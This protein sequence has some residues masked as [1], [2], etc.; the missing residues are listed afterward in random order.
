MSPD[1]S[2]IIPVVDETRIINQ[3]LECLRKFQASGNYEIIVVDGNASGNTLDA[4]NE[5]GIKKIKSLYG[6]GSQM[7]AGARAAHGRILLFLHA[8]TCLPENA[9]THA[10]A[11][12]NSDEYI[13]GAFDLG[14]DSHKPAYRLIEKIA[15]LRSR[16]T[17]IPYGDQ[18]IFMLKETFID[19]G[20]FQEIPIME[21]IDLMRRL[22][23][24]GHKIKF[25]A[26]PVKTSPRRWEK[27]GIVFG[28]IRNISL[29]MLFYIGISPFVLKKFYK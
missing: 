25:S 7:N 6:R 19:M 9:I 20:G 21:D 1:V 26:R 22:R 12:C 4:I 14:I 11:I 8:D 10:T 24:A 18:A 15:S 13:G 17:R 27:E 16:L 28:T 23:A 2:V 29:S 3:T 5:P